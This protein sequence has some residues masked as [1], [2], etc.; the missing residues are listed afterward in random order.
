MDVSTF[1][2]VISS[3]P[4]SLAETLVNSSTLVCII[5]ITVESTVEP[6]VPD[7]TYGPMKATASISIGSLLP[8]SH[9]SASF[10]CSSLN[11][12]DTNEHF[13]CSPPPGGRS[14]MF[15]R[16]SSFSSAPYS[17]VSISLSM[18]SMRL[19]RCTSSASSRRCASSD[20]GGAPGKAMMM[21][22]MLSR[23]P[24]CRQIVRQLEAVVH[25]L[26]QL[27]VA[28]HVP[29]A[30]ARQHQKLV[31]LLPVA[32]EDLRLGRHQLLALAEVVHVLVVVVAEGTAHRQATV[33]PLD[34]HRAARV[35][36][37]LLLARQD[38]FV[39]LRG[40]DGLSV[41]TQD[42]PGIA[43]VRHVQLLAGDKGANGR[44]AGFVHARRQLRDVAHRLVQLQEAGV[45]ALRDV[46]VA[47]LGRGDDALQ[48]VGRTVL[49]HVVPRV[50]IEHR[51]VVP[52]VEILPETGF[53]M[54]RVLHLAPPALHRTDAVTQPIAFAVLVRL[55][56][57]PNLLSIFRKLL[58]LYATRHC[59]SSFQLPSNRFTP[60][61]E[62]LRFFRLRFRVICFSVAMI[63]PYS[64]QDNVKLRRE[65]PLIRISS[66]CVLKPSPSG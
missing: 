46:V 54:I 10:G 9:E 6:T 4:S 20:T 61:F 19:R 45:D 15:W 51:E 28:H 11:T 35:L 24:F 33:H 50:P 40:E 8:I 65:L 34:H 7:F 18:C 38:G 25:E 36:D 47:E 53:R 43:T 29:H 13:A 48:Q 3:V 14:G 57:V 12:F 58:E 31:R 21:M 22:L 26:A 39:V 64:R 49:R 56:T 5:C 55:D 17:I 59:S 27:D 44:R 23:L 52:V 30:V 66:G 62:A 1:V 60:S 16:A 63:V 41:L 2:Y 37:T 42:S 32:A